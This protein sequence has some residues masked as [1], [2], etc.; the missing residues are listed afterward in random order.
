MKTTLAEI[1]TNAATLA[2]FRLSCRTFLKA[3]QPGGWELARVDS[4]IAKYPVRIF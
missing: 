3:N 1:I 2:T 4:S